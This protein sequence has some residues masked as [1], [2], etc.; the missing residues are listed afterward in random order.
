MCCKHGFSILIA[1]HTS[2]VSWCLRV[3]LTSLTTNTCWNSYIELLNG[4]A[5]WNS[6][7]TQI[8]PWSTCSLL[9]RNLG[10]SW[11]NLEIRLAPNSK[12]LNSH[13]KLQLVI[14]ISNASWQFHHLDKVDT[15]LHQFIPH[16]LMDVM[17]S[18]WL[19][20]TQTHLLD[21]LGPS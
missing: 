12:Q 10:I 21:W 14:G 11:G 16:L 1:A 15:W 6:E 3:S 4:M 7:C 5:S 17:L 13:M 8:V 20:P 9:Q 2:V 18:V 19:V